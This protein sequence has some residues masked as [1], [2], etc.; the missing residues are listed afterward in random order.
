MRRGR[1]AGYRVRREGTDGIPCGF[2]HFMVEASENDA[3]AWQDGNPSK[4]TRDRRSGRGYA[5][6]DDETGRRL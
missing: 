5:S 6:G 3:A 2:V 4:Q 1:T